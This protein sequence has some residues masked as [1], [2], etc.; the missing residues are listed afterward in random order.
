[1]RIV[2]LISANEEWRAVRK[3]FPDVTIQHTPY[4]ET[5]QALLEQQAF[6]F[7]QGGWGK[8]AA[9]SSTQYAID[10]F[11]PELLIN[12]GTCGGLAGEIERGAIVLVEKTVVYDIIEQMGDPEDAIDH[13]ATAID[14][15]WLKRPD[16]IPVQRSL[17]VSGDRDLVAGE[18][19]HLKK[20]YNAVAG[21]WES[22]AIAWVAERNRVC[23]LILRG[24]TDLVSS[25]GG[26][27]YGNL[28]LFQQAT[29]EI[30]QRL[31]ASLPHWVPAQQ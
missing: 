7:V 6:R 21:D 30:M 27:A 15:A 16:P 24:V 18:V 10:R 8:I 5:F 3:L 28:A 29:Q 26:E 17:L 2:V 20:R 11:Q 4:G 1:M 14:L 13:Y 25:S 22:G 19:E 31:L 12:L 9:A 23:T